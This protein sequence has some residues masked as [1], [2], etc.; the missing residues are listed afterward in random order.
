MGLGLGVAPLVRKKTGQLR[1]SVGNLFR[2][3][4]LFRG[5][6]EDLSV[7]F[8]EPHDMSIGDRIVLYGLIRGLRPKRYLEIGV[9]WGGSGRIVAHAMQANDIGQA[10][11]IDPDLTNF[12]PSK[13]ELFGRYSL[14]K[15]YSPEAIPAA[16]GQQG[17]QID[18]AFIDAVHTYSAVKADAVALAEL[19]EIGGHI[20][21]HDAYHQGINQAIDEFLTEHPDFVDCGIVSRNADAGTPVSYLGMRLVRRGTRA[22]QSELAE[23]HQNAGLDAP[24]LSSDVWDYDPYA[25]RMGDALGRPKSD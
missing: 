9:R 1:E 12:R 21:F 7:V 11:G 24:E 3:R 25:I 22:F 6:K 15:G 23:L 5:G 16:V 14:F 18:F 10:I 8:S 13:K 20:L 19:I 2:P 17:G 4:M